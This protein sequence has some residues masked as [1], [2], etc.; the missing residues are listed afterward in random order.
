MLRTRAPPASEATCNTCRSEMNLC[1]RFLARSHEQRRCSNLG[2][3]QSRI[4][5]SILEYTKKTCW[6]VGFIKSTPPQKSSTYCLLL[7]VEIVS[8]RF[9]RGGDFLKPINE[10]NTL[11]QIKSAGVFPWKE[12][13]NVPLECLPWCPTDYLLRNIHQAPLQSATEQRGYNSSGFR[14]FNFG[15][16]SGQSPNMAVTV[17]SVPFSPGSGPLQGYLGHKKP[18]PPPPL[19]PP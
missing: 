15:R 6:L 7:R 19:G 18:C 1:V 16:G 13:P 11:C 5:P 2:P 10:Y 12:E 4:P 8:R 14:N 17:L 3:T 9:C